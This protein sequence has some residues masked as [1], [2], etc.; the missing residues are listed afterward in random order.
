[1]TR[2]YDTIVCYK[3]VKDRVLRRVLATK[4]MCSC[5]ILGDI[6]GYRHFVKYFLIK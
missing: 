1:M 6:Q 5:V 2:S 4:K 3:C